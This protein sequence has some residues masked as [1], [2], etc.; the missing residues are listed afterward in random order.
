MYLEKVLNEIASTE[1]ILQIVECWNSFHKEWVYK[2]VC[3]EY[4]DIPSFIQSVEEIC[5]SKKALDISL[6]FLERSRS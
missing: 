2:T 5:G 3:K 4:K 6:Y 1:R